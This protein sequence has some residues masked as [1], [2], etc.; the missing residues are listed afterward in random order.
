[1]SLSATEAKTRVLP[2]TLAGATVLHVVPKLDETQQMRAMVEVARALIQTGARVIVAGEYGTLVEELEGF[3]GEWLPLSVATCNPVKLRFNGEALGRIVAQEQ[4]AVVHAVSS[5]AAKS[6]YIATRDGGIPLI[7]ELPDMPRSR[8]WLESWIRGSMGRGDRVISRSLYN[9]GPMMARLRITAGR[10]AIVP[11]SLDLKHFDSATVAPEHLAGLRPRWGIP[12]G[13]RIAV[14][15]GA[16]TSSHGHLVLIEAARRLGGSS[17]R[18]ITFVLV[19]NDRRHGHFVRS[20]WKRAQRAGVEATFRMV[21]DMPDMRLVYAAADFVVV[22]YT[23]APRDSCI[24]AEAQAMGRPVIVSAI[25]SLPEALAA[26]PE[27]A[28]QLRTG[29]VV[30]PGDPNGLA[31]AIE[32]G[33]S[34]D[35]TAYRALTLRARHFAEDTFSPKRTTDRVLQVYRTL[36]EAQD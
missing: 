13:G 36:L 21:G 12:Y 28:E 19:G 24:V 33:L 30:Q 10:V 31:K 34:L 20:F 22:P 9:A 8:M 1:M 14:V 27:V 3:G 17:A 11:H 35:S 32:S 4:I 25:G 26:P 29:W 2:R 16:V 15:P 6:A 7:T 18:A 5:G 23:S